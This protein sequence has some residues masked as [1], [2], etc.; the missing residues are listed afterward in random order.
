MI[1]TSCRKCGSINIRKNG[2]TKGGAQKYHCKAC[3]FYGTLVTQEEK[4]IKKQELIE[5]MLCERIS[6]RGIARTV[7]VSRNRIILLIKK[8]KSDRLHPE[9]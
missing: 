9:L 8:K 3:G 4:Q 5:K 2:L 7:R 1:N 6:Q